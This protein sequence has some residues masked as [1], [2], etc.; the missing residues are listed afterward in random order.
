MSSI[1]NTSLK[2]PKPMIESVELGRTG[3]PLGA[4]EPPELATEAG[5]NVN[6]A[7]CGPAQILHIHD[8]L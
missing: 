7:L 4:S 5:R 8:I 1:P 3:A 2:M 6:Q